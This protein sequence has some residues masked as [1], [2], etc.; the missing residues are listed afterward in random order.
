MTSGENSVKRKCSHTHTRAKLNRVWGIIRL[1]SRRHSQHRLCKHW[2]HERKISVSLARHFQSLHSSY[3]R[4]VW[5]DPVALE[6]LPWEAWYHSLRAVV[7]INSLSPN[8]LPLLPSSPTYSSSCQT[9]GLQPH[10]IAWLLSTP[11]TLNIQSEMDFYQAAFDKR[12]ALGINQK[13]VLF[14]CNSSIA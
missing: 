14:W 1:I 8:C 10:P 7:D 5:L 11:T 9:L 12:Q 3:G 13:S 4:N 6:C 2:S